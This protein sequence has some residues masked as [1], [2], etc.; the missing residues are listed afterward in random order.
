M[1]PR[2]DQPSLLKFRPLWS[3]PGYP[4]ERP[5]LLDRVKIFGDIHRPSGFGLHDVVQP[6]YDLTPTDEGQ[7]PGFFGHNIANAVVGQFSFVALSNPPGSKILVRPVHFGFRKGTAGA[8]A[9]EM[10][11]GGA[12]AGNPLV[13]NFDQRRG[14]IRA[15]AVNQAIATV[16]Q[17]SF[18]GVGDPQYSFGASD[19][20][21]YF[22]LFDVSTF[23]K[24]LVVAPGVAAVLVGKT[25]NEQ[26]EGAWA[27]TEEPLQ[28]T[29]GVG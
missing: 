29:R 27:W 2:R 1:M 3:R 8:F 16:T 6:I 17:G 9:L 13:E 28:I 11:V 14:N 10:V 5:D 26:V 7:Q 12:G 22:P 18:V 21:Q 20:I 23:C 25:A 24:R 15:I 4:L 19:A